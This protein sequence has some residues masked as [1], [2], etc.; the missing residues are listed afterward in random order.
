MH[1]KATDTAY[2]T[3]T[4]PAA[5]TQSPLRQNV[6]FDQSHRALNVII[7]LVHLLVLTGM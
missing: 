5:A 2:N 7:R 1:L 3:D 6:N 4:A